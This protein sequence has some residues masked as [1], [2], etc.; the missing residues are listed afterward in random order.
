MT[1]GSFGYARGLAARSVPAG[2]GTILAA[3]EVLRS[4][5]P[6]DVPDNVRKYNG[7]I[8]YSEGTVETGFS[9]LGMGY[10]NRWTSTDQVPQRAIDA[11]FIGRF[12]SLD[13]TDGGR[14]S[15]FS[16]RRLRVRAG[17]EACFS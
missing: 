10:A 12:G 4:N 7:L 14:S 3:A 17:G 13:P 11:G 9:I 6:W 15:R 1:L 2:A 8:R 16:G 5:G